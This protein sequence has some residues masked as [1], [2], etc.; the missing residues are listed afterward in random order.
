VDLL[1]SANH[2]RGTALYNIRAIPARGIESGERCSSLTKSPGPRMRFAR[3]S[4]P[5]NSAPAL[6]PAP[7]RV[8]RTRALQS[9]CAPVLQVSRVP[10]RRQWGH[11][12]LEHPLVS[13]VKKCMECHGAVQESEKK[14]QVAR[15]PTASSA[16]AATRGKE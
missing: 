1:R 13:Q 6:G 10:S 3:I 14:W 4:T 15:G 2:A 9:H 11:Y 12:E 8:V 16:I 7:R 5:L